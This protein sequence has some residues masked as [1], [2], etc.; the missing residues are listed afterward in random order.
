MS[1]RE[2]R[3]AKTVAGTRPNL[4][5]EVLAKVFMAVLLPCIVAVGCSSPTALQ[6]SPEQPYQREG[7]A[8]LV[9]RDIPTPTPTRE[10]AIDLS[11]LSEGEQKRLAALAFIEADKE[12]RKFGRAPTQDELLRRLRPSQE[13]LVVLPPVNLRQRP[14]QERYVIAPFRLDAMPAVV[15]SSVASE[16]TQRPPV[17][18]WRADVMIGA[19]VAQQVAAPMARVEIE[20]SGPERLEPGL[21]VQAVAPKAEYQDGSWTSGHSREPTQIVEVGTS[22]PPMDV[23]Q[24]ASARQPPWGQSVPV[25]TVRA[26]PPVSRLV[27]EPEEGY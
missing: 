5:H 7:G 25:G 11:K 8:P 27:I 12:Y 24:A 16:A 14:Q 17:M 6:R 4:L 1:N 13:Q 21:I 9:V 26:R 20:A 22:R 19:D 15:A 2:R 23:R 18:D 10:P 3:P